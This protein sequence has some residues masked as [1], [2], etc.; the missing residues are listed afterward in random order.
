MSLK[1]VYLVLVSIIVLVSLPG[2]AYASYSVA[3]K[4]A[5]TQEWS[6]GTFGWNY[7]MAT[8]TITSQHVSSLYVLWDFYNA[9]EV[10]WYREA[11]A[12]S[13]RFFAAWMDNGWYSEVDLGNAPA[14]T[15]HYY[16][17][18]NV[19]GTTNWRFYVDGVF[20]YEKLLHFER[21]TSLASSERNRLDETNYSHFWGLETR[22]YDGI[23]DDWFSLVEFLDSDPGYRLKPITNTECEMVAG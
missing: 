20:K 1:K 9:A 6:Y 8:P 5:E 14:G 13:A 18:R 4:D 10:G 19:T 22:T 12:S 16:T 3:A 11:G 21:G 15:N 23:W 7:V 17:V 2:I